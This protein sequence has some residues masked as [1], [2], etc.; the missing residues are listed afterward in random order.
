MNHLK[1]ALADLRYA[2]RQIDIEVERLADEH[3]V[4]LQRNADGSWQ[5]GRS[6]RV[7]GRGIYHDDSDANYRERRVAEMIRDV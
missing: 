3:N 1:K 6:I 4:Y 5:V 7:V 2:E